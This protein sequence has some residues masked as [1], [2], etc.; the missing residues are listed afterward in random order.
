M[1]FAHANLN[2]S[3]SFLRNIFDMLHKRAERIAVP[4][5]G[6]ALSCHQIFV[7]RALIIRHNARMHILQSLTFRNRLVPSA[8][9]AE[10]TPIAHPFLDLLLLLSGEDALIS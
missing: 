10:K 1:R 3:D 6:D 7:Y 5:D 2:A 9:D 8:A 4:H